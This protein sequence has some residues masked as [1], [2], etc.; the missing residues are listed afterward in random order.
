MA[1]QLTQRDLNIPDWGEYALNGMKSAISLLAAFITLSVS[2]TAC[3]GE[4]GEK[5]EGTLPTPIAVTAS[6]RSA[7]S[8]ETRPVTDALITDARSYAKDSGVD[9][10]E[11]VRRLGL[12]RTGPT[13]GGSVRVR[14]LSSR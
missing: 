3:G 2:L 4:Q 5:I 1:H 10:D 6:A 14:L 11:A 12:Q 13:A 9:L 8:V 7:V